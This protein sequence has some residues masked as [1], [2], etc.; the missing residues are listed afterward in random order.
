MGKPVPT[1]KILCH[2]KNKNKNKN[3]CA[4]EEKTK[5]PT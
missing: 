4:N 5:Q 2:T 3:I 1:N